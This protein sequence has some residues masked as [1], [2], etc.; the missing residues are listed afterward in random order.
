MTPPY[1]LSSAIG[2]SPTYKIGGHFQLQIFV[3]DAEGNNLRMLTSSPYST[4]FPCWLPGGKAIA[5]HVDIFGSKANILQINLDGTNL[6]RLTAGPKIDARPAF[7]PDGS[8]LAFQSNRDGDYE[9]YV[10][11]LR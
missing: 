9:I 8:K 5:F 11:N 1:F 2:D 6:T 7:S 4:F 3:M 10:M